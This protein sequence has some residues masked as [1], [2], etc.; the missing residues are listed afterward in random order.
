MEL[1]KIAAEAVDE[2]ID[3]ND[4]PCLVVISKENC[5]VC[6]EVLPKVKDLAKKLDGKALFY[7]VDVSENKDILKKYSLKGVPQMLFFKDGAFCGKLAGNVE[8]EDIE[9][10]ITELF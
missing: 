8:E 10:K 4:Q 3:N 6:E 7:Y 1:L 5:H 9:E 2:V